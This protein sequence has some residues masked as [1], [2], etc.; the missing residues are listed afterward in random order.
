[1]NIKNL[2]LFIHLC[3]SQNFSQTAEVMHISPSALSRVI[4][5]LEENLGQ[6]LLIRDNRSVELTFAGINYSCRINSE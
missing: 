5:R 1:M 6:T 2:Q 3:E 4:Q